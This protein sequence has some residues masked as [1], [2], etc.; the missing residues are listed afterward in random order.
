MT[1]RAT[2]SVNVSSLKIPLKPL[3]ARQRRRH[4]GRHPVV[5]DERRDDT[6]RERLVRCMQEEFSEMPGLHLTFIQAARLFGLRSDICSRI[7][8]SLVREGY[9]SCVSGGQYCRRDLLP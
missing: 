4:A 8:A 5:I 2:C 6:S 7:L 1:H 9:L 3:S